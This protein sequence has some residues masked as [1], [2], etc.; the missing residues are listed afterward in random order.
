[1]TA[2][3]RSGPWSIYQRWMVRGDVIA[4]CVVVDAM[5]KMVI[6]LFNAATRLAN[7]A[8]AAHIHELSQR[9]VGI[10]LDP[11]QSW[12]SYEE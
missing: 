1:M 9:L 4:M 5:N 12:P 10:F 2:A 8:V 3:V 7:S 11:L 6:T